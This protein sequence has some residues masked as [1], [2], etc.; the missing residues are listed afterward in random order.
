M[1]GAAF[2][3]LLIFII[4]LAFV[5]RMSNTDFAMGVCQSICDTRGR[6]LA[7]ISPGFVTKCN[8]GARKKTSPGLNRH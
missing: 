6:E 2:V 3:A 8:C 4:W 1:K 5:I 7:S